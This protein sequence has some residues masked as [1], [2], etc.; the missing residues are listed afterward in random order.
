MIQNKS[1]VFIII[2]LFLSVLSCSQ[3][4]SDITNPPF[5]VTQPEYRSSKEDDRCVLGGVYF[6][7]YNK[8][9]SSVI[10]LETRMNVYDRKTGK[11]AFLGCGTIESGNEVLIKSREQRKL[12]VPLDEYITVISE[13]G[14]IIDQF[15]ISRIE[16]EDGSIWEDEF[17][18]YARGGSE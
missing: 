9:E 12:C 8:A 16:Y 5:A 14:Y 6:D 2:V 13:E 18:V 17:G 3:N 15:Y 1:L 11:A 4:S 7:F 10:R